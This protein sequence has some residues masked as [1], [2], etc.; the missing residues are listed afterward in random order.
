MK[1]F[2]C[3]HLLYEPSN[4]DKQEFFLKP[5]IISCKIHQPHLRYKN[6]RPNTIL[7]V[8]NLIDYKPNITEAPSEMKI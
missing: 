3:Y 4:D 6:A 8:D 1:E 5:P 2:N 7:L